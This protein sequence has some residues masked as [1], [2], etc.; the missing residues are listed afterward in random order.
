MT[1]S[2]GWQ[3]LPLAA[4]AISNTRDES[5]AQPHEGAGRG[6]HGTCVVDGAPPVPVLLALPA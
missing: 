2:K 3:G 1:D 6:C 4:L 5:T